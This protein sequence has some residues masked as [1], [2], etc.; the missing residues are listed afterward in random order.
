MTMLAVTVLYVA[1]LF[2]LGNPEWKP[3]VAGYVGLLLMGGCFVSVGL[4]V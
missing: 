4:L 3:I 1:I 2:F